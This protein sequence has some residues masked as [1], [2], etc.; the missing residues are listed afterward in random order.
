MS[1]EYRNTRSFSD[2]AV[3]ESALI[4]AAEREHVSKALAPR[5]IVAYRRAVPIFE[6]PKRSLLATILAVFK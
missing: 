3:I 1:S 5:K 4:A 2:S 6:V